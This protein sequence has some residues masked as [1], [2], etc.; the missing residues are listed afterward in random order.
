M[1]SIERRGNSWRFIV[2]AGINNGKRIKKY[3]TISAVGVEKSKV[4][5]IAYQFEE[6]T[7]K[8]DNI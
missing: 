5:K 1:V 6:Q 2:Y 8:V 4:I 3:R 7:K